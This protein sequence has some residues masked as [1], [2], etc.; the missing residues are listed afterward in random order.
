MINISLHL[1]FRHCEERSDVAIQYIYSVNNTNIKIKKIAVIGSTGYTGLTLIKILKKH[2]FTEVTFT[3]S[4]QD[5]DEKFFSKIKKEDFDLVFF[6]TPNG[7]ASK[8]IPELVKKEI[9]VIDLS[10]DYRFKDLEVYEKWHGFKRVDKDTNSKAIYGLVEFSR[11]KI[12]E[13]AKHSKAVLIGNPGCYTTSGI[14]ALAPLLNY[15]AKEDPELIDWSSIII[16]GKSGVSGAGRKAE[17][18]LLFSEINEN[19]SAYSAAGKHRH[20]PEFEQFFSELY[21]REI[22][23]SFSPHLIPMTYGLLTTCY[24]NFKKNFSDEKLREIYKDFY[25]NENFIQLL[26]A[27]KYPETR[28]VTG[29]NYA[30]LQV[31]YDYRT[32]RAVCISAIDN[33]MKG[34]A[35]QAVQSMNLIFGFEESLGLI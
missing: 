8:Y 26:E 5:S 3:G 30:N 35:G 4:S 21:Q 25:R 22:K 2:P 18:R 9:N 34:A 17:M 15:A 7:I 12:S 20:I 23:V 1:F 27:G 28:T 31:E 32:N 14:L 19:C 10:S 29:T 6:A 11:A 16:D 33:L 13:A 24:V